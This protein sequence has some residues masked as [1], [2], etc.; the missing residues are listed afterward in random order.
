MNYLETLSFIFIENER[1]L[2]ILKGLGFSLSVTFFSA[3]IGL[4][5]G[6]LIA[7][8]R[9]FEFHPFKKW[10]IFLNPLEKIGELYVN[11]I[12]GTPAVVQLMIFANL[13]F[14]G[15]LKNTPIFIIASI[16]FGINSSAYVSEIIRSGIQG[17]D[18]GQKEAAYS[19]G[20][21]YS[22]TMKNII[23]PQSIKII[24]P[25]LISEFITLLKETSI[26]GFIGGMDLLTSSKI[27][28]SQTYRG[29]EPLIL[30]GIIYLILTFIFTKIMKKIEKGMKVND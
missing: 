27:I 20:L 18:K 29:I 25:T 2:Y 17:V 4:G 3:L 9:L 16:S 1:Y 15:Y 12:R 23:V 28:T 8:L 30:V 21:S 5:L 26:V 22:M 14:V 24:L 19:L 13:I 11:L 6:I 10:G 7:F